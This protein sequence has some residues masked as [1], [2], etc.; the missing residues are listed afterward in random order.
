MCGD[1][2]MPQPPVHGSQ[3]PQSEEYHHTWLHCVHAIQPCHNGCPSVGLEH[4]TLHT[5]SVTTDCV[6]F[7]IRQSAVSVICHVLYMMCAHP[8]PIPDV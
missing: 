7:R 4:P 5:V 2:C 6:P 1:Q 3:P 8:M